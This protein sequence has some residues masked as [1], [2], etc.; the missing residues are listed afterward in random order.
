L[1]DNSNNRY[2]P[3]GRPVDE[4]VT[5]GSTTTSLMHQSYAY[6]VA[7]NITWQ[8]DA[9]MQGKSQNWSKA[10]QYDTLGRLVTANRGAVSWSGTPTMTT[11]NYT[12][13]WGRS[14]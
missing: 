12:G 14:T 9:L 10:Y 6:D 8:Y 2:D 11:S 13:H 5:V 7:G 4:A 3:W 1:R